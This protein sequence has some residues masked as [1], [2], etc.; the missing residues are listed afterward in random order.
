MAARARR[1][2][3]TAELSLFAPFD[4]AA[5]SAAGEAIV[6]DGGDVRLYRAWLPGEPADALLA[7]IRARTVWHQERRRMYDRFVDVP[8]EQ[9]WYGD[10]REGGWPDD[11]ERV[12]RDLEALTGAP[13]AFVLLNRYRDGKD[14]VAWH[15]DHETPGLAQPVIGSLTLGATRAFDLRPKS[16]RRRV[17]SI[18]LEHGDLLVMRGATQEHWEHRVA[19][20]RRIAGERINLTFRQQPE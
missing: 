7:A 10:D 6:S 9:A 8:R 11:L 12:R 19:K 4:E 5:T 1:L 3:A 13:F 17:I 15:S 14:S 16:D 2:R 18:D 20:D